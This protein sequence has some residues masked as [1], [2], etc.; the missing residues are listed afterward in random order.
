MNNK[1]KKLIFLALL[2][3]VA[4]GFAGYGVYS[5]YYT[6]GEFG[7]G[8]SGDN[9]LYLSGSFDPEVTEYS[10]GSHKQF[11]SS[12]GGSFFLNCSDVDSNNQTTCSG[13]L[14][15]YNDGS[16]SMSLSVSNLEAYFNG[17]SVDDSQVSYS[18]SDSTVSSGSDTTLTVTVSNIDV[19]N[20]SAGSEPVYTDS[21]VSEE[22][23]SVSVEYNLRVD[24]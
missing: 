7:S 9:N 17:S 19:P 5:Y 21:P 22:E 18:L 20:E 13:S 15:I 24:D 3:F 8:N 12:H 16:T 11:I 14:Y 2:L 4:I 10:D 23:Y 6:T 1:K